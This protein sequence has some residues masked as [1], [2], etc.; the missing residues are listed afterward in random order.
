MIANSAATHGAVLMASK[1][2]TRKRTSSRNEIV[3]DEYGANH[4][5]QVRSRSVR[6]FP[7][8]LNAALLSAPSGSLPEGAKEWISPFFSPRSAAFLPIPR[9]GQ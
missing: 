5:H 6:A 8:W 2:M 1:A 7:R 9:K 4:C 3:P